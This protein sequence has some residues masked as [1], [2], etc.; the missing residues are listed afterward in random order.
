MKGSVRIPGENNRVI[1]LVGEKDRSRDWV[2]VVSGILQ[3]SAHADAIIVDKAGSRSVFNSVRANNRALPDIIGIGSSSTTTS[4]Q[5]HRVSIIADKCVDESSP[6]FIQAKLDLAQN[7][8][9]PFKVVLLNV[10]N[11]LGKEQEELLKLGSKR[12]WPV[13]SLF[14]CPRPAGISDKYAAFP[15]ST[16]D[17]ESEFASFIHIHLTVDLFAFN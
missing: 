5:Q 16:K 1:I 7:L 8:A 2:S 11:N 10:C 13:L 6:A 4:C 17:H 12:G 14:D 15:K 9:G 3:A